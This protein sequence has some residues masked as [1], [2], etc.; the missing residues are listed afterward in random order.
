MSN[1]KH[2]EF[3]WAVKNDAFAAFHNAMSV[4]NTP[5]TQ[6]IV[7]G[8]L[9][10]FLVARQRRA[11][12]Q[13]QNYRQLIPYIVFYKDCEDGQRRYLAYGRGDSGGEGRL[14]GNISVGYGGHV[15]IDDVV[16]EDGKSVNLT[17]TL[18]VNVSRELEEEIEFRDVQTGGLNVIQVDDVRISGLLLERHEK[19]ADGKIPVGNVHVGLVILFQMPEGSH[20]FNRENAHEG[21]Q[22]KEEPINMLTR[23]ELLNGGHQLEG[24][25]RLVLEN[26]DLLA[27]AA[28]RH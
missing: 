23:E 14:I 2:S 6:E 27:A 22:G 12:E 18:A 24:W 26:D 10:P 8:N 15:D 28:T 9:Q 21:M 25:T 17:K 5:V 4:I 20:A 16:L 7:L 3:I 19:Q 1:K 11:L 13:D